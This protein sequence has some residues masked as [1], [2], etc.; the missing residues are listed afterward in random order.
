MA[1]DIIRNRPRLTG[2]VDA[3][4]EKSSKRLP[5]DQ[6]RPA[7][8]VFTEP[9]LDWT[10]PAPMLPPPPLGY[11]VRAASNSKSTTSGTSNSIPDR[12]VGET[13]SVSFSGLRSLIDSIINKG[14]GR[15]PRIKRRRYPRA[16][17]IRSLK[18]RYGCP[19]GCVPASI[20][21]AFHNLPWT[22]M[23]TLEA[24]SPAVLKDYLA[25]WS[26]L[27]ELESRANPS[28]P[29]KQQP[30]WVLAYATSSKTPEQFNL[31]NLTGLHLHWLVGSVSWDELQDCLSSWKGFVSPNAIRRVNHAW[32]ALHYVYAQ[33]KKVK[34]DPSTY[35]RHANDVNSYC[36]ELLFPPL[37]SSNLEAIGE[38]FRTVLK[39]RDR[40][41]RKR[42][43]R[44]L[45][46]SSTPE[47]RSARARLG[48]LAGA[49]S[50][51]PQQR[52]DRS[53]ASWTPKARARREA[54]RRAKIR[55]IPGNSNFDV[56]KLIK[57]P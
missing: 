20:A 28:R 2:G 54:N 32:G 29:D 27:E 45:A 41:S 47:E 5:Q 36:N 11:G 6:A 21:S 18:R 44:A 40:P 24:P 19:S 55:Q 16:K 57:N 22:Y 3:S 15:L 33:V 43:G 56:K 9:I 14:G 17:G 10:L 39:L 35:Y 42:A 7:A 25:S 12:A 23:V 37:Q 34:G 8:E 13:S 52:S 53:R 46:A 30:F 38:Y 48:G 26:G 1:D 51:T 49:S 50:M 4:S 31:K